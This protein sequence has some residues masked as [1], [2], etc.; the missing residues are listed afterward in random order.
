MIDIVIV[1]WNS[2]RHL[3]NCLTALRDFCGQIFVVDNHSTDGSADGM[4]G[5]R[6]TLIRSALNLGFGAG[7]NLGAQSGRER[8]ILFL[9]PDVIIAPER[10]SAL[11]SIL[12]DDPG[13]GA[14]GPGLTNRSD[15]V[16]NTC[17]AFPRTRDLLGRILGLDRVGLVRPAFI[18]AKKGQVDQVMGA[19]FMIRRSAFE[20]LGGFDAR[21]FL[22]FEEVDL[23][24]RLSKSGFQI[25]CAPE[26][27]AVHAG[28]GSSGSIKSRRL[29]LW[30][31]SRLIYARKHL[32]LPAALMLALASVIIEPMTRTLALALSGRMGEIAGAWMGHWRYSLKMP[33]ILCQTFHPDYRP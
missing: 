11:A 27:L 21:F 33:A 9:N 30:L 12:S 22:Y 24:C 17:S 19:A 5:E 15:Q 1:N 28:H 6:V 23:L 4:S 20:Q 18:A 25:H 14:C 31:T 16:Q 8:F 32:G 3:H 10:V 26:I 29:E 2:G 7:C 13:I